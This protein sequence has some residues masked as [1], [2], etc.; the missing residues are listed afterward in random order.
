MPLWQARKITAFVQQQAITT[1]PAHVTRKKQHEHSSW[2]ITT[3]IEFFHH[4]LPPSHF[5]L[6][7]NHQYWASLC[8][9]YVSFK[10]KNVCVCFRKFYNFL[11][12]NLFLLIK[13]INFPRKLFSVTYI[14]HS[15]KK[16]SLL[17]HLQEKEKSQ[18][19]FLRKI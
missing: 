9:S 16:V 6:S 12:E 14:F 13:F 10:L 4:R 15:E 19:I 5:N 3:F 17:A 8:A 11:Y 7:N 18:I 2:R 1:H